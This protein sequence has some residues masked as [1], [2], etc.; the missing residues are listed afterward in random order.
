MKN[1][2]IVF[3]ISLTVV[4]QAAFGCDEQC[5]KEKAQ[6]KHNVKF[7]SYL[8][9]KYCEGIAVDFMTSAVRSLDSYRNNHFSTKYK[10]PLKNTR[11]FLV[12]RKDWLQECDD[13]LIKTKKSR[14]FND[15][16]T[17]T[18]IFTS[19]DNVS[20]EFQALIKGASY[21]SN[22]DAQEVMNEKINTLFKQVEDHKTI[23]HLKGKYVVR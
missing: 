22:E 2:I 17:T 3:V 7:P 12:Q 13:Y 6:A 15:T 19:I 1:I 18:K 20:G 4:A 9:W 23:M 5:L 21:A 10:G 14:V 8:T 11:S 16:K